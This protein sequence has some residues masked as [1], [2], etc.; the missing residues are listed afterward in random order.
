MKLVTKRFTRLCI[1]SL[2][3]VA[4]MVG[5]ASAGVESEDRVWQYYDPGS[6]RYGIKAY[7]QPCHK[8]DQ[9][10]GYDLIAGRYVKQAYVRAQADGFTFIVKIC[11]SYDS[12]RLYSREALFT[13]R[14]YSDIVISTPD[15]RVKS[16]STCV[17]RLN[18]GWVDFVKGP[19]DD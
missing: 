4:M 7:F 19:Y 16:C 15:A 10:E 1:L 17:Q 13:E 6:E 9:G 12:G 18:Y 8:V 3:A 11:G 5:L 2:F 14:V